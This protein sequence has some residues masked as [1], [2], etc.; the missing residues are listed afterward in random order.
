MIR[1]FINDGRLKIQSKQID[2]HPRRFRLQATIWTY[3]LD[4]QIGQP[5]FLDG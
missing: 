5:G 3:E 1:P 4:I 2:Y